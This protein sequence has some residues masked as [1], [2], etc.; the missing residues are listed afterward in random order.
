VAVNYPALSSFG[1]DDDSSEVSFPSI[2]NLVEN[3]TWGDYDFSKPIL[4]H[5]PFPIVCVISYQSNREYTSISLP[6]NIPV[7]SIVIFSPSKTGHLYASLTKTRLGFAVIE[8]PT[9]CISRKAN[10]TLSVIE[11]FGIFL[12]PILSLVMICMDG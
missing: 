3:Q 5:F 12:L 8:N 11:C 2:P 7:I 1:D 10:L 6:A 9:A 4:G